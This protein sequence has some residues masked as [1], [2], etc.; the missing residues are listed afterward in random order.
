MATSSPT[1]TSSAT[2][3]RLV[4]VHTHLTHVDFAADLPAVVARAEGIGLGAVV[5]NG[6]EPASNRRILELAKTYKVIKPACGIYPVD[7][8]NG[9]LPADF[10]LKVDRFDVDQEIA[11]ITAEAK[12]GRLAAVGECGLDGHWLD[13]STFAE[14]ERVF[15][16][17]VQAAM[18]GDVPVII[19]TRKLEARSAEILKAMG[20]K[21]VNFH[22]FGGKLKLAKECAEQHGW[23]FSIPANAPVNEAFQRLLSGLPAERLLTETDAPYLAPKRGDRNEP[24]NVA[25]TVSLFAKLRGWSD[26]AAREQ[27]WKNYVELF[28]ARWT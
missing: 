10:A 13:A 3:A 18:D 28:G 16:A 1:T 12:A 27:I 19:H 5:V 26:E 14:Q 24:A 11:W 17:L 6:L 20:A 7:A 22:C 9:L 4:D 21:K 2:T 25:G 23:W 15:T 8:V